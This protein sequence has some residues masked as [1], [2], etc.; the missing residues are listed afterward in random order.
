MAEKNMS[1]PALNVGCI[2]ES[3]CIHTSK[4]FDACK[5]KDCIE[6]LRVYP[7]CGSQAIIDTACSIRPKSATLIFAD[8]RVEELNFNRGCYAVD[9]TYFYK[10]VGESFPGKKCVSG[11]AVFEKRV[12]LYGS[13]GG[14][15]VFTSCGHTN[16]G[17]CGCLPMA[18]VEAV[19]PLA[20]SMKIVDIS[21]IGECELSA[22]DIPTAITQSFEEELI[23]TRTCKQ[24][25]VTLGQF[26]II[27]L[28]RDTQL[29]MPVYDYCIPDKECACSEEDPCT[30]FGTIPFPVNDF[31]PPR[32][33]RNKCAGSCGDTN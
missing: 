16:Y 26:S 25:L 11:L 27:R 12:I 13:E 22:R 29:L 8:V 2:K 31:F 1:E 33:G 20:L 4:I 19:D 23:T 18:V 15:K 17:S 9:V 3:A 28:E 32:G 5:D 24:L 14:S 30:L 10:I 6:D 21:C 7:T